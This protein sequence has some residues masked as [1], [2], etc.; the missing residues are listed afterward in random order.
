MSFYWSFF[1]VGTSIRG[2]L[3]CW[4]IVPGSLTIRAFDG[5]N[6]ERVLADNGDGTLS[7]NGIGVI[8]YSWGTFGF[9]FSD[10]VPNQGTEIR[11]SYNPVEGGCAEDCGKCAT[12]YLRLD[13]T[14]SAMLRSS[15][16]GSD[17]FTM[18]DA[19]ERL[20]KKIRRDILPI[21]LEILSEVFEEEFVLKV[22]HRFDMID[23]DV[24]YLD[25]AELPEEI[26]SGLKVVFDDTSW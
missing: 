23:A 2:R 19:W 21:H 3:N 4:P 15:I 18:Q 10:P 17:E 24:E 5:L 8:N 9:D 13:I 26:E 12:H 7:G 16:S 14:P 1:T 25:E 6:S 22:G 20:F 11:A